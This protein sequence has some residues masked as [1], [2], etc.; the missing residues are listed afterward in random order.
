VPDPLEVDASDELA[1][2]R[3]ELSRRPGRLDAIQTRLEADDRVSESQQSPLLLGY[4]FHQLGDFER[5]ARSF[6]AALD[7]DDT[8]AEAWARLAIAL[9]RLGR[10]NEAGTAA[11][12]ALERDPRGTST[13]PSGQPYAFATVLGVVQ[14]EQGALED[15]K[16]SFETARGIAPEDRFATLN[17]GLAEF[18][19]GDLDRTQ[20]LVEEAMPLVQAMS[21]RAQAD[22]EGIR[23]AEFGAE[24][25]SFSSMHV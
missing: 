21:P 13:T 3:E 10:L 1:F 6:R 20:E 15:A 18:R 23:I 12:E 4:L 2:L 8:N 16:Q 25:L 5:S 17:L 9:T 22:V 7:V 14:L 24:S 19:L 11:R